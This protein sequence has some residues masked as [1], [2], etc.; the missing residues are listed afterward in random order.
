MPT[1]VYYG[2][3]SP[4]RMRGKVRPLLD[5]IRDNG[6]TPAYAG[7]SPAPVRLCWMLGD[8]PRV[9]GEKRMY[10]VHPA[11]AWGSPPRMRGKVGT[12]TARKIA[13]GITPAYAGKR[14]VCNAPCK[15][16]GDHP[17]VCGEKPDCK[18]KRNPRKGSPPR[19]RGKA[20]P[21]PMLLAS[22]GI[23]PAYAGKSAPFLI[24]VTGNRD[25]PRVCGE[26]AL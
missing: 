25:H 11:R 17:R 16:M 22:A 14:H 3:G 21:A 26:K 9:C 23:T 7:K 12:H 6:I 10:A 5:T 13:A 15:G 1:I 8:H 18:A 20:V 24:L 4:P 19:M 2:Q